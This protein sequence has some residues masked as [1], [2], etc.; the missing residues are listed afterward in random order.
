MSA[1]RAMGP[2]DSPRPLAAL[3]V[4]CSAGLRPVQPAKIRSPSERPPR[5]SYSRIVL[6]GDVMRVFWCVAG[7]ATAMVVT[8][9]VASAQAQQGSASAAVVYVSADRA[10]YRKV[11]GAP[12]I[13]SARAWGDSARP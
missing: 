7:I 3:A 13:S 4:K 11:E 1:V 8:A 9:N 5:A 6:K 10:N 12:Q 2:H